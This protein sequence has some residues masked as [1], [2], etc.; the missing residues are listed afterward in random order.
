L[1]RWGNGLSNGRARFLNQR[2]WRQL[3]A[4]DYSL[5]QAS[6]PGKNAFSR[7]TAF[8]IYFSWRAGERNPFR[9]ILSDLAV[10]SLSLIGERPKQKL[11]EDNFGNGFAVFCPSRGA[12]LRRG[13]G[14]S[15][16]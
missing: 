16:N 2:A 15:E 13:T 12:K 4:A 7:R 3:T 11:G 9:T 1:E 8:R 14:R 5:G 6:C 10:V